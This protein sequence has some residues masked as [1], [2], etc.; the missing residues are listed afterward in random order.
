MNAY[1]IEGEAGDVGRFVV[2]S[3]SVEGI[4]WIVDVLSGRRVRCSCIAFQTRNRCRHADAT[5]AAWNAE[6][7]PSL[8][9]Q[10]AASVDRARK[11]RVLQEVF[12]G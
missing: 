9:D 5:R 7:K 2:P 11:Q 6:P 8:A 12:G 10:L 1:R 3:Q 4:A